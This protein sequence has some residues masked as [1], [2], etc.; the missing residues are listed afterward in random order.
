M[1]ASRSRSVPLPATPAVF[2]AA[3]KPRIDRARQH[4]DDDVDVKVASV[5]REAFS[6]CRFF[7]A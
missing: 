2:S 1:R 6:I 5:M 4:R 7:D 3:T